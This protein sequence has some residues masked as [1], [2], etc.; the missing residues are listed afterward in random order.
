MDIYPAG[1]ELIRNVPIDQPF[2]DFRPRAPKL[3]RRLLYGYSPN[4]KLDAAK[5]GSIP[6]RLHAVFDAGIAS[7]SGVCINPTE[8]ASCAHS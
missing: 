2:S 7:G 6:A 1:A 5:P 3:K 8:K 4:G